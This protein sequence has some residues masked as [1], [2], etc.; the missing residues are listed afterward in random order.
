MD[1]YTCT[2]VNACSLTVV[3]VSTSV[4]TNGLLKPAQSA[5][6]DIGIGRQKNTLGEE[7][8]MTDTCLYRVISGVSASDYGIVMSTTLTDGSLTHG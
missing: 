4:Y 8:L 3:D 5:C 7:R 1:S 6:R 2:P